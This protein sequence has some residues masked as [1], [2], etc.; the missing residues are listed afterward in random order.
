MKFTA[1]RRIV[2][3]MW[4]GHLAFWG[5][6]ET[7]ASAQR[8]CVVL[9]P[10]PDDESIGMGATLARKA[11]SGSRVVVVV[12][13]DGRYSSISN[14]ISEEELIT[15]RQKEC[16]AA[17][18]QLGI[19][20]SDI[21]FLDHIDGQ[22]D[23]DKLEKDID[24][25]LS[26]LDFA[27]DEIM[28]TSIFDEHFDHQKC[29]RVAKRIAAEHNLILRCC[30]LYWWAQG[31]WKP[32]EP[33]DTLTRLQRNIT[34]PFTSLMRGYLV[35]SGEFEIS[36]EKA[37]ACYSSQIS[38]ITGEATWTSLDPDWLSEFSRK[39]EFFINE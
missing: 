26:E 8:S 22:I 16:Q 28:S 11:A 25:I 34:E 14:V 38:N 23:E 4:H 17:C 10:H 19:A 15:I 37:V 7:R 6:D 1:A 21:I 31:P 24:K 2:R 33:A 39:K 30:P 29:A 20:E 32:H 27:P 13:S 5:K 36:R 9:S 12:A 35:T 3:G 18:T